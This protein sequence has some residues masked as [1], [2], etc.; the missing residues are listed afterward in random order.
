MGRPPMR[1]STGAPKKTGTSPVKP[2]KGVPAPR[3]KVGLPGK[4]GKGGGYIR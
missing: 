2:G 4:T 1:P 3:G